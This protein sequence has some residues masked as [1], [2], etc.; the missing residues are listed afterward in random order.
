MERRRNSRFRP[1]AV[2]GALFTWF[3]LDDLRDEWVAAFKA[4]SDE[5]VN[6][7]CPSV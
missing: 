2:H 1:G 3:R 7:R 4:K 6:T 5:S